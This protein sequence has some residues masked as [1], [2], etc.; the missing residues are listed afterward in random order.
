MSLALDISPA[1]SKLA[2]WNSPIRLAL[3]L[4]GG[5][6]CGGGSYAFFAAPSPL[7]FGLLG[8]LALLFAAAAGAFA[9][10]MALLLSDGPSLLELDSRSVSLR[11][12]RGNSRSY[13]WSDP[14]ID[15]VILDVR[16]SPQAALHY[17]PD[18]SYLSRRTGLLWVSPGRGHF[19][20]TPE[21][22]DAIVSA[23]STAGRVVTESEVRLDTFR[24]V[25]K[26]VLSP[27]AAVG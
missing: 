21:A 27:R 10:L 13:E 22:F 20:L 7:P 9:I 8:R 26:I 6:F 19:D 18:D 23:A 11:S 14:S 17:G 2:K 4:V 25:R 1:R 12:P 15:F 5:L 3:L 24:S 16:G